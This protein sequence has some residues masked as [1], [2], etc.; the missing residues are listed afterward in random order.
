VPELGSLGSVR[1]ALSNGRSYR[2][3]LKPPQPLPLDRTVCPAL[4]H[5]HVAEDP[6]YAEALRHEG[7]DTMLTG[8]VDTGRKRAIEICLS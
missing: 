4:V 6:A 3:R 7:I 8:D 5:R 1:G 2:E